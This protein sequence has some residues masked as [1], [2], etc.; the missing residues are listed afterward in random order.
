M[1]ITAPALGGVLCQGHTLDAS[2][3]GETRSVILRSLG[4]PKRRAYPWTEIW[5]ALGLEH[6]QP[7]ALWESLMLGPKRDNTLWSAAQ[8][9]D[10]LGMTPD[11]INSW[12]RFLSH[13]GSFGIYPLTLD[14]FVGSFPLFGDGFFLLSLPLGFQPLAF[15]LA[16]YFLR[17]G[18]FADLL[19]IASLPLLRRLGVTIPI[20]AWPKDGRATIIGPLSRHGYRLSLL[21]RSGGGLWL[22]FSAM[23]R[24]FNAQ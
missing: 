22:T 21:L 10:H 1:A 5:D 12:Y 24:N 2:D 7:E 4:L 3:C 16:G 13:C 11:T 8:V 23:G 19:L 18:L 6:E 9:A 17:G 15:G 14:T 20:G